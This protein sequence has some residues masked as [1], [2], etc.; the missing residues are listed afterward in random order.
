MED[1]F[2]KIYDK[3]YI[4]VYRLSY[5]YL[6]NKED[7]EDV[8]QN[9]FIKLYYH[10]E[11]L[12]NNDEIII[13]WLFRVAINNSKNNL[14]NF[15]HKKKVSIDN[16]DFISNE[17]NHN[18]YLFLNELPF[19]YR[20]PIYLYYYEGYQVKEIASIMKIKESTIKSRLLRGKKVL[21]IEM[22]KEC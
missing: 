3:H 12:K 19:K 7:A 14:L 11:I 21:R 17:S 15:W 4:D 22:E 16:L 18:L 13:K 8:T 1:I 5:S 20:I 10:P 2:L 6:L 9:T